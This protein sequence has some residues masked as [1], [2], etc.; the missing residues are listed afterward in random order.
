MFIFSAGP[1]SSC[2]GHQISNISANAGQV[3]T[4][5]IV[6]P[7]SSGCCS[8]EMRWGAVLYR[9]GALLG[10]LTAQHAVPREAGGATATTGSPVGAQD[11]RED[12]VPLT[13]PRQ[14]TWVSASIY[15]ARQL[16]VSHWVVKRNPWCSGIT[17]TGLPIK[18]SIMKQESTHKGNLHAFIICPHGIQ[19]SFCKSWHTVKFLVQ[20]III[21]HGKDLPIFVFFPQ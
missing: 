10:L 1:A 14:G 7:L 20:Q 21:L 2:S 15:V 12:K 16:F 11:P 6:P 8:R 3:A 18:V 13:K 17:G 4:L 19:M 5:W 9:V